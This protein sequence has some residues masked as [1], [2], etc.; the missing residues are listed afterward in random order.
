[1]DKIIYGNEVAREIRSELKKK[2]EDLKRAPH[3]V[4]I[5]VGNNPA[6]ETYVGGKEKACAQVG[7]KSSVVRM[8]DS[9]SEETLIQKI[10]EL[11]S[12]HSVDGILVQLP[13]PKHINE[14][15]VL[16]RIDINKD[17]DGFHP[18]NV[19]RLSIGE[20]A[21]VSCTPLG[22]MR[23]LESVGM[24]DLSAKHVVV[25]G[26]SNIVGKPMVQLL[27]KKNAT[28]SIVHSKTENIKE[29]TK[30]ADILIVAVGQERLVDETYIKDGVTIIDVGIH[31]TENGLCGDVNFDRV[32]DKVEHITP[33]PKGVGPMTIAML[34]ENT[35]ECYRRNS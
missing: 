1:M 5:L 13:L 21:I 4:V 17:V 8:D 32:I 6:S 26:R 24:D 10:D 3:L 16:E 28:L 25:M 22:I 11:N 9:I 18:M 31:R 2:I 14:L 7:M 30:Q 12:D 23:L 15:N 19:G 33:V 27:L 34:L 35:L 20:D 29:I